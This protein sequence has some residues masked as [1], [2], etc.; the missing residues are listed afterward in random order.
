[1]SLRAEAARNKVTKQAA[2]QPSLAKSTDR[3]V[4]A[5]PSPRVILVS[6]SPECSE[7]AAK[8]LWLRGELRE[9][10]STYL[11]VIARSRRRRS[12]L[13]GGQQRG[14]QPT[15]GPPQP[16]G[17]CH[18][19]L[20]LAMTKRGKICY[21]PSNTMSLIYLNESTAS[22]PG[23]P[24]IGFRIQAASGVDSFRLLKAKM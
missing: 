3:T 12:K 11:S 18:G 4:F 21:V 9:A 2:K 14:E 23:Y 10:I 13:G 5:S 20:C 6:R 7:G 15:K 19:T 24:G 8:N 1:M 16:H 17:D 22:A